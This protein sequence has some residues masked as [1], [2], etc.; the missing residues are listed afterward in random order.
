MRIEHKLYLATYITFNS[1]YSIL[2]NGMRVLAIPDY[3]IIWVII[4]TVL[5]N[6]PIVSAMTGI[7]TRTINILNLFR[8]HIYTYNIISTIYIT[9]L[10]IAHSLLID[11]GEEKRG[12]CAMDHTLNL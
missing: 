2:A 10:M 4:P 12:Y 9:G 1:I 3:D 11:C 8:D 5:H 7:H 6:P